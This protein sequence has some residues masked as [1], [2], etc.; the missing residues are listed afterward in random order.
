MCVV[1]LAIKLKNS[2]VHKYVSKGTSLY[3][4]KRWEKNLLE[5]SQKVREEMS[6]S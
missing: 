4:D 5:V 6:T 1:S 3:C 2:D